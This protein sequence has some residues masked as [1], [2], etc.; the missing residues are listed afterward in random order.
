V[1]PELQAQVREPG[2]FVQVAFVSQPPL[3][4]RHSLMSVQVVPLPVKPE[5]QA[6]VR[7]PGVFVQVA[8]VSQPPLPVRH[9]LTSTH[10]LPDSEYPDSQAMEHVFP[11]QALE[12]FIPLGQATQDIPQ[13][14]SASS[15]THCWPHACCPVGQPH[16]PVTQA[17]PVGQSA[18]SRQPARH[19]RLTGSQ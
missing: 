15:E 18:L 9:S 4:V 6:Q 14:L 1:K 8:F 2:V 16:C 5:L 3:P 11:S 19:R 17:A 13:E 10:P 12:P 7:E